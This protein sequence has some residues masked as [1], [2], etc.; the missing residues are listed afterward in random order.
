[1]KPRKKIR[2]GDL[3]VRHKIIS[4]AQLE[5][6]LSEQKKTG[7]KLGRTLIDLGHIDEDS[8]LRF[9]SRQLQIPYIDLRHYKFNLDTVRLVPEIQ[10]RRY[11]AIALE[12]QASEL[13]VGM[14]DPTDIFAYDELTRSVKRTIKAAV[15]KEAD[16]LRTFDTVYRRTQEITTFASELDEEL[17]GRDVDL[18]R[19][20]ESEMV[21]DAPVVKLIHSLFED[22]VQINA[23]DIH[24]EPEEQLLRIR[25]RVDGVLQEQV[26]EENRIAPALVLRLKL[27][28]G[29]DI[30]EKRLPQDGRFTVKVKDHTIDVRLATMPVQFGES[31]VL[32]LLDQSGGPMRLDQVGMSLDV[33]RRFEHAI[34]SPHGMVLVTGPTGSGKTT[35]L[36]AALNELNEAQRKI[37]TVEDPVEYRLPRVN[38]VQINN[39]IGLGFARVLR[40]VLRQDPD[41][42]LV[43]EMRDE[44][45]VDIGLRAA[46][47]GHLVLSTLHT[48]DSLSTVHRL[49]D[50]G[51]E[52]YVVASSLRAVVAQRLMRRVCE[53]CAA[54]FT[55]KP[56]HEA[57]LGRVL[58][59]SVAGGRFRA[60]AGCTHCNHTGYRGRVGV[61]EILE[62][63]EAL[64]DALSRGSAADFATLAREKLGG[65]TLE[66]VAMTHAVQGLTTLDEA[67]TLAGG[68]DAVAGSPEEAA[69]GAQGPAAATGALTLGR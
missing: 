39:D 14:A 68:A 65:K 60:G 47:T 18:G 13:L 24:I 40:S 36:Y 58:G 37:I 62:I 52:G 35:T 29:L 26:M 15:V 54:E 61:F 64:Q 43:G 30:A 55:P 44:E 38:Q 7:R 10:A 46:M 41:V 50:M 25:Q 42:V 11:R 59:G 12:Q 63:D 3:L 20:A 57:W 21:A 28:A 53:G 45:T 49:L 34:A 19:L 31:V 6:A 48:N 66:R 32:R 67:I 33:R 27:M 69:D 1:M 56:Y 17:F 8:L 23:S 9:L 51:A 2:L 5:T 16:L 4:Q 22:A